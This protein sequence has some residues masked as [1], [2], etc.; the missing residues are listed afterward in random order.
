LLVKENGSVHLDL[1]QANA[2]QLDALGVKQ[3]EI[4][5]VCTADH[6]H[7][8]FSWRRENADTGRFAALIALA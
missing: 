3:I 7:D 4:A 1:W 6:T 2:G 5:A 8:F